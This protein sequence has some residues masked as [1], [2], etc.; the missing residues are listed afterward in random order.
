MRPHLKTKQHTNDGE[1]VKKRNPYVLPKEELSWK[2]ALVS[3]SK[4]DPQADPA[5]LLLTLSQDNTEIL[6]H[7]LL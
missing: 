1:D 3:H 4:I 6:A 5:V 2:S 7:C